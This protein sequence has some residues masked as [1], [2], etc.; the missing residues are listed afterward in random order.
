MTKIARARLMVGQALAA[1]TSLLAIIYTAG[2]YNATLAANAGRGVSLAAIVLS[3]VSFV[4]C[5]RLR[6][7]IVAGLL[8]L[9]GII[10][11]I[12]PV[13]AIMAAGTI[14]IPGPILGVISYAIILG[15]GAIKAAG[16]RGRR[17]WSTVKA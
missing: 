11:M 3:I 1:L 8:I 16:L 15:L 17:V 2:F 14:V 9:S 4:A 6:S 10:M 13:A 5:V 12:P 7:P